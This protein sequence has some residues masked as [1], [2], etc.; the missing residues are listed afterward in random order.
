VQVLLERE[1]KGFFRAAWNP[2]N[3]HVLVAVPM[4]SAIPVTVDMRHVTAMLMDY[5]RGGWWVHVRARVRACVRV[6][7]VIISSCVCVC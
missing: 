4:G 1:G 5:F 7:S 2:E 3:E 6:Y